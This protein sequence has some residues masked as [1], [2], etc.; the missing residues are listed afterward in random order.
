MNLQV[1]RN[2]YVSESLPLHHK[3]M[4]QKEKKI[5]VIL[6]PFCKRDFLNKILFY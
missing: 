1:T 4:T 3:R 6:F 5:P 2:R